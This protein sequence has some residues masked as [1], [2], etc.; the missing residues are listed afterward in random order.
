MGFASILTLQAKLC[1]LD[2]LLDF[3]LLSLFAHFLLLFIDHWGRKKKVRQAHHLLPSMFIIHFRFA[4]PSLFPLSFGL[5]L[6]F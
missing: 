3:L 2:F 5:E 1:S 4:F 6:R